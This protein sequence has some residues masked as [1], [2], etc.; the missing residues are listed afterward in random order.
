MSSW[1]GEDPHIA[2]QTWCDLATVT[3]KLYIAGRMVTDFFNWGQFNQLDPRFRR[4]TE[5]CSVSTLAAPGGYRHLSRTTPAFPL[6]KHPPFEYSKSGSRYLGSEVS[7]LVAER[8]IHVLRHECS[9]MQAF[10][11]NAVV[12]LIGIFAANGTAADINTLAEDVAQRFDDASTYIYRID[13][14]LGNY[15]GRSFLWREL[16]DYGDNAPAIPGTLWMTVR[17]DQQG[18][19]NREITMKLPS[20]V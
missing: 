9:S 13:R 11:T 14:E 16:S 19:V 8:I 5:A 17:A 3:R 15:A 10:V 6:A 4:F 12:A 1:N 18:V 7:A 20:S 2:W